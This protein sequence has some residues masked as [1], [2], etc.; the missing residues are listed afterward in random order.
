MIYGDDKKD[1]LLLE[2]LLDCCCN[3]LN[4]VVYPINNSAL[5]VERNSINCSGFV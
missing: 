4:V 1:L 5:F 3:V 2:A